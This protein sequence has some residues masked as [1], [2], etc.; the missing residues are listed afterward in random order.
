MFWSLYTGGRQFSSSLYHW[1]RR[2]G[3]G[4]VSSFTFSA[5]II[6]CSLLTMS[7]KFLNILRDSFPVVSSSLMFRSC[8]LR[9]SFFVSSM[10]WLSVRPCWI[11]LSRSWDADSISAI[12]FL[13]LSTFCFHSCK[14]CSCIAWKSSTG[15]TD[16]RMYDPYLFPRT[17]YHQQTLTTIRRGQYK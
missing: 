13:I 12:L 3:L 15:I 8:V 9:W 14:D 10:I 7:A 5:L 1:L 4:I 6:C 2:W 11:F 16:G 17:T